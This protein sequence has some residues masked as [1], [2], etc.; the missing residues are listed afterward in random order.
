VFK[1]RPAFP[2]AVGRLNVRCIVNALKFHR[3]CQCSLHFLQGIWSAAL[4]LS[5][6]TC[7][8]GMDCGTVHAPCGSLAHHCQSSS[9]V[10]QRTHKP[11]VGGS[12]PSSGTIPNPTKPA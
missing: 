7:V 5:F 12:I 2:A 10:E 3:E 8:L 1:F 9:G 6:K 11:L 4:P